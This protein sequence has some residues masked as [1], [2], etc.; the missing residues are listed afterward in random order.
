MFIYCSN[1][2]ER[3]LI[4]P[5]PNLSCK[6]LYFLL[7]ITK[8]LEMETYIYSSVVSISIAH[9][10]LNPL[11][12]SL[13]P[14][15]CSNYSHWGVHW[16]LSCQ[17]QLFISVLI[18]LNHSTSTSWPLLELWILLKLLESSLLDSRRVLPNSPLTS[19]HSFSQSSS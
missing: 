3:T 17:G 10:L 9:L 8:P 18:L 6:T 19:D 14:L 13:I 4:F 16:L 5:W 15:L 11:Q 1:F 2:Y 12:V 7:F